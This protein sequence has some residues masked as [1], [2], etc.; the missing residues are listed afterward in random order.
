MTFMIRQIKK[1]NFKKDE[2][3]KSVIK[4]EEEE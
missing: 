3:E 2:H 4:K 1:L